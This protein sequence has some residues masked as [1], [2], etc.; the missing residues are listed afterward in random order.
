LAASH[1]H[2]GNFRE[3][4]REANRAMELSQPNPVDLCNLALAQVRL[5]QIAESTA[6]ARQ[7]LALE[8]E[9]PKAHWT[10]G[11]LL[12]RDRS[13]LAEAAQHLERAAQKLPA[14]GS[15]WEAVRRMLAEQANA[16]Q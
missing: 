13:T 7:W 9:N 5:G 8:P 14:A 10:L 15:N 1:L 3:T 12:A 4:A 16:G 11:L 2:T 6:A